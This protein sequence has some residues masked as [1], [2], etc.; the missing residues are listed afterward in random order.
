MVLFRKL[1]FIL[2]LLPFTLSTSST[3]YAVNTEKSKCPESFFQ[4]WVQFRTAIEKDRMKDIKF[5]SRFPVILADSTGS[6][7]NNL[8]TRMFQN[9][10]YKIMSEKCDAMDTR[11][12]RQWILKYKELPTKSS[13]FTCTKTWAQFCN[14]DF[15][16]ESS[17][18]RLSKINTTQKNLFKPQK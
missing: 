10:F 13:F 16:L 5:L 7:T 18:W 11:N 4:F 12:Q 6:E 1:L 9:I 2:I 8:D 14:F 17:T 15:T 3:S